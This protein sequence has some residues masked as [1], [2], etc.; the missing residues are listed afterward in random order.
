[1]VQFYTSQRGREPEKEKGERSEGGMYFFS[2]ALLALLS[3]PGLCN[4]VLDPPR[5][6]GYV[7]NV[8]ERT[9]CMS[10]STTVVTE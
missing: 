5:N 9:T 7:G 2:V 4:D 3:A 1:M 8:L 10:L 6:L